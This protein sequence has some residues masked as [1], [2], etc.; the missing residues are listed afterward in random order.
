[1]ANLPLCN[2]TIYKHIMFFIEALIF[3]ELSGVVRQVINMALFGF[4]F[5]RQTV[6]ARQCI[7]ILVFFVC[8]SNKTSMLLLI[9]LFMLFSQ[10]GLSNTSRQK[11]A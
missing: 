6:Q 4:I 9:A 10:R 7:M 8:L 1:M 11:L 3:G 5:A 2:K